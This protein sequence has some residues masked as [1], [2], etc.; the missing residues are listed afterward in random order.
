MEFNKVQ[1]NKERSFGDL[2]NATF[3]FIKQEFAELGKALLYFAILPLTVASVFNGLMAHSQQERV[4]EITANNA[5]VSNPWS[6]YET[7]FTPMALINYVV[8][9]LTSTLLITSVLSYLKLYHERGS[10]NFSTIDVW[11]QL[12]KIYWS[13]F[14][15]TFLVGL[16][17][18]IGFVFCLL[19]GI[20]LSVVLCAI[21]PI[22][23]FEGKGFS[24]AFSKSMQITKPNFWSILGSLI[25]MLII[26]YILIIIA[27]IPGVIVGIKSL[28]FNRSNPNELPNF[29]LTYYILNAVVYVFQQVIYAVPIIFVSLIYF[30][31]LEKHEKP[32]LDQK[33]NEIA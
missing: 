25:V 22:I 24:E 33:I 12:T 15:T 11:H 30:S 6:F 10:G 17:T 23:V 3:A 8:M 27:S 20:Y 14:G 9:I 18:T 31:Q 7:L 21:L 29:N 28:L 32:S 1:L 2:F 13:I 26:S 16:L 4:A 5:L 19:P